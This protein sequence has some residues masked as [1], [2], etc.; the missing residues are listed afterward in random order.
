MKRTK[1]WVHTLLSISPNGIKDL[2]GKFD[3]FL[4]FIIVLNVVAIILESVNSIY[5]AYKP[6]FVSFEL[7]SVM[8]FSLEYLARLWS[9]TSD[10]EYK[11]PLF[12]RFK[13]VF[14]PMAIVDLLAIL[15]FYVGM[16]GLDL[17]FI[18]ALRMFR[19]L[20]LFKIVRYVSALRI[21]TNVFRQ[22]REELVT[23]LVFILF[24][25]LIVS[26]LMFYVEKD[27]EGTQFTSI[28]ATMWWGVA[29]LTTVGYGD[30]YPVT[31]MGRFLGGIIAILGI[32]L[33]ALPAGI[34]A[35]G[36]SDEI[37]QRRAEEA[38]KLEEREGICSHCGRPFEEHQA[39]SG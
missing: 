16:M 31:S 33:F 39:E 9:V 13:F 3:V 32:G 26:C 20:R 15:P 19:L 12:G 11:H 38:N 14:T 2:S 24:I 21:I 30:I 17:R 1:D 7:F 27:V 6:W 37:S 28:P 35:A 10:P 8:L 25:L 29:T 36:C 18:R 4:I 5:L 23:S 34:L 22:K